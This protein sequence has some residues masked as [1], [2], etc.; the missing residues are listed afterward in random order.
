MRTYY[1]LKVQAW[2][3]TE[4]KL[5]HTTWLYPLPLALYHI[6]LWTNLLSTASV[7][8]PELIFPSSA[9][10]IYAKKRSPLLYNRTS[11][12]IPSWQTAQRKPYI[13]TRLLGF[14]VAIIVCLSY[15]KADAQDW[16]WETWCRPEEP[17]GFSILLASSF[18]LLTCDLYWPYTLDWPE[19]VD[20]S[21]SSR[22]SFKVCLKTLV[23]EWAISREADS[24]STQV[25]WQQL[26]RHTQP[27]GWYSVFSSGVT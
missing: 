6:L 19:K 15:P 16:C 10:H 13:Q 5:F 26:G 4:N 12:F 27:P 14:D 22:S 9:Y 11:P 18:L 21:W 17:S 8:L 23:R 1:D 3:L 2:V 20:L 25:S 24:I 7:L